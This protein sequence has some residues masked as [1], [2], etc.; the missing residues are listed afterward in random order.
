MVATCA[1]KNIIME[2]M[3]VALILSLAFPTQAE[4]LRALNLNIGLTNNLSQSA[5]LSHYPTNDYMSLYGT[6]SGMSLKASKQYP[7]G[8]VRFKADKTMRVRG[9]QVAKNIYFGQAKVGKKWGLGLVLDRGNHY[10]GINNRGISYLK[11]F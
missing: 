3:L 5:T 2:A 10:Y 9:W 11:K 4:D 6:E 1:R 8:L 7:F